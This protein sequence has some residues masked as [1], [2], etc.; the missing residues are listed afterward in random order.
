MSL[1]LVCLLVAD[2]V[3]DLE[4]L[5]DLVRLD[6]VRAAEDQDLA[7]LEGALLE[8][9]CDLQQAAL[10]VTIGRGMASGNENVTAIAN[11]ATMIE[12]GSHRLLHTQPG[13][14]VSRLRLLFG[15]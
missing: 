8:E 2:L 10:L 13:D 15:R 14:D 12:H 3:S 7:H 5:A 6:L 1:D 4:A 11:L 9:V